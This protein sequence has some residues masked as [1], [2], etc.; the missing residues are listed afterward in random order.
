MKVFDYNK[1]CPY[2]GKTVIGSYDC[3]HCLFCYIDST[4][5]KKLFCNREDVETFR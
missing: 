5:G 3:I 2:D 4:L 1:K